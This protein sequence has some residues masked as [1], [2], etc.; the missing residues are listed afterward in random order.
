[1]QDLRPKADAIDALAQLLQVVGARLD[2]REPRALTHQHEPHHQHG[3][4]AQQ[5]YMNK[6]FCIIARMSTDPKVEFRL[7]N[8]LKVSAQPC[9]QHMVA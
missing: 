3:H 6:Y 5:I 7:Q 8:V 2:P 9:L 1:M 4:S